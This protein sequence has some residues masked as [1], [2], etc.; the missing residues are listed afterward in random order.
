MAIE[1]DPLE[2]VEDLREDSAIHQRNARLNAMVAVMAIVTEPPFARLPFQVTV[3]VPTFATA[4]PLEAL[5][6]T[7]ARVDG[8]MSMNSL[9]GLFSCVN[10]PPLESTTV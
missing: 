3:R 2:T 4:V 7:R 9:P 6:L 10:G 5:A 1:I 8:R